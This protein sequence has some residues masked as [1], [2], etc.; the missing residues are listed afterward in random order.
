MV[1]FLKGL[2]IGII[3]AAPVGPLAILCIRRSLKNRTEGI[4]TALGIS[5]TDGFYALIVALGLSTLSTFFLSYKE[6]FFFAGGMILFFLGWKAFTNPLTINGDRLN[7]RGFVTTLLQ[8]VLLTI[9][10][11]MTIL[12]FIA[13]FAAVGFEA[14]NTVHQAILIGSGVF[15]GSLSWF[16]SLALLVMYGKKR[17]SPGL[18]R[19][20][21]ML[22]GTVLSGSGIFFTL[23]ALK[24]IFWP[25]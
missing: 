16:T 11:P 22:S 10:N 9:S 8:T 1:N 13:T 21:N 14:Q 3:M 25:S 18:L 6:Y 4:A 24:E 7:H 5:L 20:I 2:A 15:L 12:T 17:I 23:M 19:I